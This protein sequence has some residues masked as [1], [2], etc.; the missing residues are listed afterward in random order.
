MAA[1]CAR[2]AEG[3]PLYALG[4]CHRVTII[5]AESREEVVGAEDLAYDAALRRVLVSAHD[6]ASVERSVK[7]RAKDVPQGGVYAIP[8]DMLAEAGELIT[9]SSLV[10]R[11]SVAGGL[12]PHGID[13][14]EDSRE[15]V[16]VNRAYQKIDRRWIRTSRI[17]RADADGALLAGDGGTARC[18]ANDVVALGGETFI[19]FDHA[20][21]GWRGGVEDLTGARASGVESG[22]GNARFGGARH[23]NGVAKTADG[24]LALAST[25]DRA[26]LILDA[27]GDPLPVMRRIP[28]PGAPDNLTLAA[29]GDI[30]AAVYP[31]LFGIGL[32]R[33]L[34]IGKS[35]SRVVRIDPQSGETALL[36]D[37][38]EA[39]L[40]SAASAAIEV[41]GMIVI[42]SA[43]DRGL[44]VCRRGE[45]EP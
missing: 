25:R 8:I 30:I 3:E 31:S 24:R 2:K 15:I 26:I 9:L 27:R 35:A 1:A 33:R 20:A 11:E 41:E 32:Q 18:S 44:V 36:F 16:F 23:A 7:Q 17:E 38:P 6:R 42:G 12:R 21:C 22:A 43:L 10:S 19:S 14:D 5:D 45:T 39:E 37:D 13:F 4:A 29:S 40:I 34:G 28:L